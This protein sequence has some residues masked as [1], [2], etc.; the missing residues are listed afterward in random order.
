MLAQPELAPRAAGSVTIVIGAVLVLI[1]LVLVGP[2]IIMMTGAAW[3]ALMGW[4]L[5]DNADLRASTEAVDTEADAD[6]Q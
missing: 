1:A 2:V 5:T 4:S 3:S 6:S